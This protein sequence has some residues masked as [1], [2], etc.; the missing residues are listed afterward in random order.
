MIDF[1]CDKNLHS[2]VVVLV[3]VNAV[4]MLMSQVSKLKVRAGKKT[5]MEL[6]EGVTQETV[7]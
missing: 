3:D 2:S 4:L 6:V 7:E 5:K 1:P